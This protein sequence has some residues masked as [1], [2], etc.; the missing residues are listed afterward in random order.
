MKRD[1]REI[2]KDEELPRKKLPSFHEVEFLQKLEILN[3][4]QEP[5]PFFKTWKI[6]ASIILMFSV[7]YY[8]LSTY[9][10][11]KQENQPTLLVQVKQIEKEYLKNIKTEWNTFVKLTT[12]KNL[13]EKYKEK[14]LNLDINYK[15]VSVQFEEN[16]NNINILESLINNLQ[17]RL[18]LLKN[19]KEHLKELNQK[20]T[21]NETIYL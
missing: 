12:D 6:A 4:K 5:K 10:E 11:V 2:F 8:F 3:K 15:E 20:N 21:S 17:N 9:T 7:G 1:I 19:I 16:P 14:L 13:I 18:Q